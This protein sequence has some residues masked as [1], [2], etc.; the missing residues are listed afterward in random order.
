M[1]D[2]VERVARAIWRS[3]YGARG[4]EHAFEFHTSGEREAMRCAR[5]AI[6]A[7]EASSHKR[8][9]AMIEAAFR[10]GY[11]DGWCTGTAAMEEDRAYNAD[12]DWEQSNAYTA[13]QA[14]RPIAPETQGH[15][16]D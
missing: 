5:A 2:A 1:S 15:R 13:M 6:T 8:T 16:D 9:E 11:E 14:A 7:L 12:A 10:E 3:L 4:E